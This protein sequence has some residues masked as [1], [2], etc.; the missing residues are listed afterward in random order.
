[1]R[2]PW[3]RCVKKRWRRAARL[4]RW[5]RTA[6]KSKSPASLP[7]ARTRAGRA[8]PPTLGLPAEPYSAVGNILLVQEPEVDF[9][10]VD[11]SFER[12]PWRAS[13]CFF[14]RMARIFIVPELSLLASILRCTF[15]GA[16][17]FSDCFSYSAL[18]YLRTST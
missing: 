11:G 18:A 10:R 7:R 4:L 3:G 13:I 12:A 5:L 8:L 2:N 6:A 14:N 16:R 9:R 17:L 15:L 1:S